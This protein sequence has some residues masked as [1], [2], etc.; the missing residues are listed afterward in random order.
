MIIYHLILVEEVVRFPIFNYYAEN[1]IEVNLIVAT[2]K[3]M[4]KR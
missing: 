1:V 2:V 4:K 3:Y